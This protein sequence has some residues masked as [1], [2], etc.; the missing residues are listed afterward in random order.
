MGILDSSRTTEWTKEND[1]NS[2][3]VFVWNS[4]GSLMFCFS[5]F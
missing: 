3:G 4:G 2:L 1:Y 5:R